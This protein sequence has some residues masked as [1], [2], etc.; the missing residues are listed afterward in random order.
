MSEVSKF[1]AEVRS[2]IEEM[3]KDQALSELSHDWMRES[4]AHKY[5]YNFSWMGRPIIQFPQD[6]MAMQE[7]IWRVKPDLIIETGIAH[8]GSLV[9]YAVIFGESP[10]GLPAL[11][12]SAGDASFL[13]GVAAAVVPI[14]VP[15]PPN[16]GGDAGTNET[17][18]AGTPAPLPD[19]GVDPKGS[20][21]AP[22]IPVNSSSTGCSTSGIALNWMAALACAG[23]LARRRR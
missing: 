13:Q 10:V 2:N 14:P 15:P 11:Y 19:A 8:G 22:A 6:L 9:F 1:Y 17:V 16:A 20:D 21:S 3:R 5:T 23:L 7:I 4:A 12:L 18:D